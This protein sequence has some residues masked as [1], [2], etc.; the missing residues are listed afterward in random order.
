MLIR[1]EIYHVR[2]ADLGPTIKLEPS[3][4][5][6]TLGNA[7]QSG[8]AVYV[9]MD[10]LNKSQVLK[11]M[12]V[13]QLTPSRIRL[14]SR[15]RTFSCSKANDRLGYTPIIPLQEGLRRTIESYPHL[16]A[17]PGSGKEGPSKPA[18]SL[19]NGSS[20]WWFSLY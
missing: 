13:P 6:G 20:S 3:E 4:D 19:L 5:K 10:L 15:S 8:R 9:S 12:K 14:L 16:R 17:E 7:M 11:G 2:I 18:A 1:Y